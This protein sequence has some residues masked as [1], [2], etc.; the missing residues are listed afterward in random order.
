MPGPRPIF[1]GSD[2][3]KAIAQELRISS[4]S[5]F[6][7]PPDLWEQRLPA[8]LKDRAPRYPKIAL[9]ETNHHLRGGAWDPDERL[10]DIALDGVAAEVL[11]PTLAKDAWLLDDPELEEACI[12]VY[13]DWEMEFCRVAPARFWGL[14]MIS[15]HDVDRAVLEMER[16]KRGGLRGVDIPI[17]PNL[18]QPY[19]S[20]RYEKLWAAAQ[21]LELPISMHINTGPGRLPGNRSGKLP[22]GVHKFD[23]MKALGDLIG[24]GVMER[25]PDVKFVIAESGSGWIPF[26]AQEYDYYLMNGAGR[27]D[28]VLPRPPSE[29][30]QRQVFTTFIGDQ[31]A[32]SLAADYGQDTFMWSS[33]YPHPACTWPHSGA[34]IAQDLGHLG[35][36]VRANVIRNT[37]AR[38]YNGGQLPPPADP[39]GGHQPLGTWNLSMRIPEQ[40]AGW[41]GEAWSAGLAHTL[42][43]KPSEP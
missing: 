18:D 36:E 13:N 33:D 10:K 42:T 8:K 38:L 29:Y 28:N 23:C 1:E 3:A 27:R 37:V 39:P 26:F 6:G 15:L 14:A 24:S 20:D 30:L 5:H 35:P 7:E 17:A 9:Y 31:V 16:C 22:Y 43:S 21:A 19:S 2:A 4:D 32:G 25:Y 12:C 34:I 40:E 41:T 11:Y